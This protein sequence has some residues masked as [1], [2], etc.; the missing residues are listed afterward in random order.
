MADEI[1]NRVANSPLVTLDLEDYYPKGTRIAF[2]I[3]IWLTEGLILR[4]KEFRK[5][6]EAHDW[7]QYQD[8]YVAIY[9][10]TDAIIPEWAYLLISFHLLPYAKKVIAGSLEDLENILFA[11]FLKDFDTTPFQDRPVIIKGCTQQ[12]IPTAA[13]TLLAAK[14]YPIA[15]RIMYG[16]ACSSVPLFKKKV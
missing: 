12:P 8:A 15:K 7:T 3:S 4:E 13:Y 9:C 2:D 6:A 16:E 11:E 14:L 1:I 5:A 10:K